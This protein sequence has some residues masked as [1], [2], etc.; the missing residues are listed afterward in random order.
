M[1][2]HSRIIF[3]GKMAQ[4]DNLVTKEI[5][6]P[7]EHFELL[8]DTSRRTLHSKGIGGKYYVAHQLIE[9]HRHSSRF[10]GLHHAAFVTSYGRLKLYSLM[11]KVGEKLVYC[12]TDS[13]VFKCARGEANPLQDQLTGYLGQ[14]TDE[15]PSGKRIKSIVC[16]GP[17]C[18]SIR[19]EDG[20]EVVKAKGIQQN[21]ATA[22][23]TYDSL[24][25]VVRGHFSGVPAPL[26]LPQSTID[27]KSLGV[28]ETR[29]F[30]KILQHVNHKAAVEGDTFETA[31][32]VPFGF[33][34][35]H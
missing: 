14:L 19:Y 31:V 28:L 8:L 34:S 20:D 22:A 11:E 29:E 35:S 17:K 25:K 10:A 3:R 9:E 23:L 33:K 6:E 4:R 7:R 27:R 1:I 24:E 21:E 13:L 26:T 15:V 12:D 30:E 18:Y 2:K 32:N 5:L 16:N